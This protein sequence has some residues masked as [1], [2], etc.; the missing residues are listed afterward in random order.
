MQA[1]IARG[2]IGDFRAPDIL[3]FGFAPLY[4]SYVDIWDSVQAL[5]EV[6]ASGEWN[7]PRFIA[8]KS[9]T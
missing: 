9:V 4:N 3:R 5:R 8:R 7:A 2:V 1:L 6:L